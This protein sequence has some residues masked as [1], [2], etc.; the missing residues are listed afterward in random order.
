MFHLQADGDKRAAFIFAHVSFLPLCAQQLRTDGGA[1]QIYDMHL[2]RS[3]A[4]IHQNKNEISSCQ[5]VRFLW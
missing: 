3:C 2:K 4:D 1:V 5:T